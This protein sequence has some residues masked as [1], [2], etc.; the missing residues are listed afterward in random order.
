M[1]KKRKLF[2]WVWPF[3]R[4]R[5]PLEC[6]VKQ[7]IHGDCSKSGNLVIPNPEDWLPSIRALTGDNLSSDDKTR[8]IAYFVQAWLAVS[9]GLATNPPLYVSTVVEET[10]LRG[11]NGLFYILGALLLEDQIEIILPEAIGADILSAAR[12]LQVLRGSD[13]LVTEEDLYIRAARVYAHY[14]DGAEVSQKAIASYARA[15]RAVHRRMPGVTFS[16]FL[17]VL[18]MAVRSGKRLPPPTIE[19]L[20]WDL[21][22]VLMEYVPALQS[23]LWTDGEDIFPDV[24]QA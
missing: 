3:V 10:A 16:A 17:E 12:T 7:G 19:P 9:P 13:T 21:S 22:A 2:P 8:A 24:Y 14:K 1:N 6:N 20:S 15:L 18:Q 11:L 5:N 4:L 23:E